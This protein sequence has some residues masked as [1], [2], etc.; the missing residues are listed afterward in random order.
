VNKRAR[1]IILGISFL[2]LACAFLV[3]YHVHKQFFE[4]ERRFLRATTHLRLSPESRSELMRQW[5]HTQLADQ[6]TEATLLRFLC[7][8]IG[9]LR[10]KLST[11]ASRSC[12]A[13]YLPLWCAGIG[14][15]MCTAC[16]RAVTFFSI[17]P[18]LHSVAIGLPCGI[19][20][21]SMG[22]TLG[23]AVLVYL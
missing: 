22:M 18:M 1:P 21:G 17:G 13:G 3:D 12:D 5:P 23:E 14:F 6:A 16:F 9:V 20:L 2:C 11:V 8:L 15:L 7:A 19:L 4:N 10:G